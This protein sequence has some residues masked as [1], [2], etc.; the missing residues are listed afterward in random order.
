MIR[1][2]PATR[3]PWMAFRGKAQNGRDA[4]IAIFD[5]PSNPRHPTWWMARGYGYVAADPF[6]AHA[7]GGEPP[8]TGDMT[9]PAGES[10]TFR[11]RFLFHEGDPK[12]AKIAEQ[13]GQYAT[14]AK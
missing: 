5:H 14:P 2:A 4:G 9:I 7:I 3:A 8:G 1:A 13:Y 6:G 11:Y 12:Q 10:I